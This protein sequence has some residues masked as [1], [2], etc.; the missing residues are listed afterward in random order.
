MKRSAYVLLPA[1][2]LVI[3]YYPEIGL[4]YDDWTGLAVYRGVAQSKNM[5]G[6]VCMFL[7]FFFFWHLLNTWRSE[8]T[9]AR[10]DELLLIGGILVMVC[11]LLRAI[12]SSTAIVCLLVA[13]LVA[14]LLGLRFVNKRIVGAYVL[15]AFVILVVAEL[16]F[17]ISAYVI[18]LLH[19]D[20]TLS[21]RTRLWADILKIKINPILG[22]G[23]ES[24]W[25]GDR[26]VQL[27]EGRAFQ[28]NE[29]HNGYLETYVNL[30]L[31]GLFMLLAVI[32]AAYRKI[33]L[34]LLTD[35]QFSRFRLG[36]LA[37][38]IL[39]NWTEVS[40]RGANP[41]WFVFYIIALDYPKAKYEFVLQSSET[42]GSE[43][44]MEWTYS[45]GRI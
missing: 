9:R 15:L 20:P 19:K 42:A 18:E 25:L 17:G 21:D 3:K 6:C 39:Y 22:V 28:P 44:E 13:M 4:K 45:E 11:W 5:M 10:R 43:E 40:F 23:F 32:I 30:G 24:F 41:I 35:F 31:V 1:S 2:I 14:G 37:A 36:F 8:R 34:G 29:A 7:G 27:H 26:F 38:V 12:Q 33:R 16:T